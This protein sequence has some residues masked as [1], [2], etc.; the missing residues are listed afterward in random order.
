MTRSPS[1]ISGWSA[2]ARADP[3][4]RRPFG[5]RQDLRDDD[6]DVVR[7]D[8]G[9]DDRH[10]L[11]SSTCRWPT[12]TRGAGARAR[13]M[14]KRA[15]IRGGPIGVAGE[16]DVLGQFAWAES[17][18]VLPFADRERDAVVRSRQDLI[19]RAWRP[20]PE[21]PSR[22]RIGTRFHERQGGSPTL[23]PNGQRA[24]SV[25][26]GYWGREDTRTSLPGPAAGTP[27]RAGGGPCRTGGS[28]GASGFLR[29]W[30]RSGWAGRRG[31]QDGRQPSAK[32]HGQT[33][34][35]AHPP[36]DRHARGADGRED[37]RG[38]AGRATRRVDA[39]EAG[40]GCRT[41]QKPAAAGWPTP[42][43]SVRRSR[44]RARPQRPPGTDRRR[45][46]RDHD[47]VA[48]TFGR[49]DDIHGI[50][51]LSRGSTSSASPRTITRTTAAGRRA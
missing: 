43:R 18:V 5:D 46:R 45:P 14:S 34:A 19:P 41:A 22:A 10:P 30:G 26:G 39:A 8:A 23:G 2:A 3:D 13:S 50:A 25:R 15:A 48:I 28:S 17:D 33:T 16:E 32:P 1:S 51:R 29:L 35:C 27:G 12:R 37:E 47:R 11:A 9:R 31:A 4:E 42:S 21:A 40:Q 44:L 20:V 49:A 36:E 38:H 24:G 6:L 7:A